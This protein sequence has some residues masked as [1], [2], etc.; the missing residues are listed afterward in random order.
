MAQ[1]SL[2]DRIG[3]EAAIVAAVDV[4]YGRVLEDELLSP[5][6]KGLDMQSQ[7]RKQVAFMT[8]ALGGPSE[9]RGKDLRTA[10]AALVKE[11]GLSDSHFNAVIRHLTATLQ[12]LG[13]GAA[14]VNEAVSQI[15]ALRP[16]VLDR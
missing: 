16:E 13:V 2:Y 15:S 4:F 11:K 12:Q 3:G 8:W 9:Y 6:F 5:F 14:E 7:M 10:H 1:T